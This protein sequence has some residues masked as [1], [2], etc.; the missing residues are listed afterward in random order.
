MSQTQE[1]AMKLCIE[2]LLKTPPTTLQEAPRLDQDSRALIMDILIFEHLL[3]TY[4]SPDDFCSVQDFR[5]DLGSTHQYDLPSSFNK[6]WRRHSKVRSGY[7]AAKKAKHQAIRRAHALDL[8]FADLWLWAVKKRLNASD[9]PW[10][11]LL[12]YLQIA[13]PII[14]ITL[15]AITSTLGNANYL[16]QPG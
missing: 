13:R 4:A 3:R 7:I 2:E 11:Q 15:D 5:R 9:Q 8:P 6:R 12:Q 1:L 16:H 10:Q 14:T